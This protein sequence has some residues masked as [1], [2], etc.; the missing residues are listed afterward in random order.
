MTTSGSGRETTYNVRLW[1]IRKVTGKRGTTYEVRWVAGR[2]ERSRSFATRGLASSFHSDLRAATNRGEPFDVATGLPVASLPVA[3]PTTW[4]EWSLRY[5]ELK[6]P[7]LAPKSRLSL[8]EALTTVTLSLTTTSGSRRPEDRQLRAAMMQWAYVVPRRRAGLP[9]A[10]L[11]AALD[12]LSGNSVPLTEL[13]RPATA[14]AVLTALSARLD[15]TPAAPTT[16]SRK[17]AVLFNAIELAIE[18]E[19]LST[20]PLPKL[21]WRVP[22]ASMAINPACVVNPAQARA[23]LAA[24]AKVP[25][26]ER[27]VAFFGCMYYAALRPSEALALSSVD[28]DLPEVTGKWGSLRLANNDPEVTTAWT[29][30]GFRE[31]RQLKHRGR[32]D[33]RPVPCPPALVT[34][35]QAHLARPGDGAGRLFVGPRGGPIK[36]SVYTD[37]WQAARRLAFTPAEVGS[38]LAARPYDLRHAAVSTWLAAGVD[39]AQVAAWAGHSIAVLHRTYAHVLAGREAIARERIDGM[40]GDHIT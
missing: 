18:Q 40:L 1:N 10:E 38:P 22:K 24:V 23:L 4:W 35:L 30:A 39:S 14:R 7:T 15:G 36:E 29:D 27:L 8:A 2:R 37:V 9:S 6:W 33:I 11:T 20:N 26:G 13:Q 31:A 28:L 5:V 19:L 21:R 16:I 34:L 3:A 17:R 32:G 12:W 25:R